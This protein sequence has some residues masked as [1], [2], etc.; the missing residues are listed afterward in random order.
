MSSGRLHAALLE[1]MLETGLHMVDLGVGPTPLMYFGVFQRDLDGGVQ[2]TG[3]H[4]P[5]T[6]T[7]S[8]S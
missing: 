1:G 3:S 2:I 7:A 4:N 6:R 8:R 5:P